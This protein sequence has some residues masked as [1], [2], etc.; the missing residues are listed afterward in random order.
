MDLYYLPAPN[1]GVYEFTDEEN[2]E[3]IFV[4]L[5]S[6]CFRYT[7]S[8]FWDFESSGSKYYIPQRCTQK[9]LYKGILS[10]Y[11][12]RLGYRVTF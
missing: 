10:L 3:G 4:L 8:D 9:K 11:L 5:F 7:G 1:R 2:V 12:W 6:Q